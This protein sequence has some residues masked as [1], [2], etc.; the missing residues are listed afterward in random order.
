MK[1]FFFLLLIFAVLVFKAESKIIFVPYENQW[2]VTYDSVKALSSDG[3][4]LIY[5]VKTILTID[6]RIPRIQWLEIYNK[7]GQEIFV[8]RNKNIRHASKNLWLTKVMNYS[9]DFGVYDVK[10]KTLKIVT[11]IPPLVDKI[12]FYYI[13][14]L[15]LMIFL[16]WCLAKLLKNRCLTR[17][18]LGYTFLFISIVFFRF[19]HFQGF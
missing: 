6:E 17:M 15:L 18:G 11:K 19:C 4:H 10:A 7:P 9:Q 12:N 14:Y 2:V 13:F 8:D 3:R 1:N 5:D 16:G